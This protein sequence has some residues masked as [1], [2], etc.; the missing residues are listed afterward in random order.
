MGKRHMSRVARQRLLAAAVAV[1]VLLVLTV[2][3]YASECAARTPPECCIPCAGSWHKLHIN[4]QAAKL[5]QVQVVD[6]GGSCMTAERPSARRRHVVS[7]S[8]I[9]RLALRRVCTDTCFKASRARAVY[10]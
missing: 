3:L 2:V 6:R 9:R 4:P 10:K 5:A 8:A 7:T 1:A